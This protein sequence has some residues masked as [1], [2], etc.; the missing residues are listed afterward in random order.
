[1]KCGFYFINWIVRNILVI[2]LSG[3]AEIYVFLTPAPV[4]AVLED[5]H[6]MECYHGSS[7]VECLT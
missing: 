1:M 5:R 2:E 7:V 4:V 6:I 3:F